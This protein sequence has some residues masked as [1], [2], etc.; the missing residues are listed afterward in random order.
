M[1][2]ETRS[3]GLKSIKLGD[4]AADGGMGTDLNALGLTYQDTSQFTQ[5]DPNTEE[6]YAEE[7]DEAIEIFDTPAVKQ[8]QYSIMNY[9]PANLQKLFGGTVTGAGDAAKWDAPRQAAAIYQSVEVITKTGL[10][11]EIP[12]GK[13]TAK[14]N[15]QF[16]KR[17]LLLIDISIRVMLPTKDGVG[18]VSISK[19]AV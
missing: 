14:F 18:P 9:S 6:L 5:G 3:V 19:V 13:V 10:K 11:I 12:N 1:A 2:E 15:G 16:R 4:V 17:G 8:I 7:E